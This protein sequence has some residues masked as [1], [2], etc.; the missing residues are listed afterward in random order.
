LAKVLPESGDL[1]LGVWVDVGS[2]LRP[3]AQQLARHRVVV[4]ES[5]SAGYDSLWVGESFS[6]G[7]VAPFQWL[8]ALAPDTSMRIGTG[9]VLLPA[10]HPLR[11][12]HETAFLDQLSDGRLEIGVGVGRAQLQGRFGVPIESVA[13]IADE[14]LEGLRQLW[15]GAKEYLG[16]HVQMHGP[17]DPLPR[18]PGGPRIWVGG[19]LKRSVERAARYGDGWYA[20]TTYSFEQ[21]RQQVHRYADALAGSAA[22]QRPLIAVNRL[23]LISDSDVRAERKAEA[24]LGP[25]LLRY[26]KHGSLGAEWRETQA[27]PAEVFQA[28]R[29]EFTI[30]GSPATAAAELARYSGLGV[31]HLHARLIT[32]ETDVETA[33]ESLHLLQDAL[34]LNQVTEEPNQGD[35]QGRGGS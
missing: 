21:I 8:A 6:S 13:Q 14:T 32:D 10:W 16:V 7:S 30:V 20:S 22:A 24:M 1:R 29:S 25:T 33:T 4:R 28:L 12:A 15:S 17:L 26:A 23:V 18:Q 2:R 3:L 35:Q 34:R 5:E 31:N 9:I 19:S 27:T 11:L